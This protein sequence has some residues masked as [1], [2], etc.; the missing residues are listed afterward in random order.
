[1]F[2]SWIQAFGSIVER[3]A[4]VYVHRELIHELRTTCEVYTENN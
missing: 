4:D 3:K 1:M 2:M